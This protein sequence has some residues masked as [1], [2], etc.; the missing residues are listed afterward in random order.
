MHGAR[1]PGDPCK[2]HRFSTSQLA[3]R[4]FSGSLDSFL[5]SSSLMVAAA[6]AR[7]TGGTRRQVAPEGEGRQWPRRGSEGETGH[8]R[9]ATNTRWG[10]WCGGLRDPRKIARERRRCGQLWPRFGGNLKRAPRAG[11]PLPA[12]PVGRSHHAPP[13]RKRATHAQRR[14][15]APCAV[16]RISSPFVHRAR[17]GP[18]QGADSRCV[19]WCAPSRGVRPHAPADEVVPRR[20]GGNRRL[21][22][23]PGAASL[24]PAV[25]GC[26]APAVR[27]ARC[28]ASH[29]SAPGPQSSSCL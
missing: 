17:A 27:R 28:H 18:P 22:V 2:T 5:S 20:Q 14:N 15:R 12:P 23:P 21:I 11:P 1:T 6:R 24:F 4:R 13:H 25:W 19:R 7:V 3:Q 16:P 9:A 8:A 26:C 10:V 29:V